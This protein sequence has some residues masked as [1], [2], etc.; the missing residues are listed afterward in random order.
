MM[1][2]GVDDE[3]ELDQ[4]V[5]QPEMQSQQGMRSPLPALTIHPSTNAETST[6][7]ANG[8]IGLSQESCRSPMVGSKVEVKGLTPS[9]IILLVGHNFSVQEVSMTEIERL[10]EKNL[11]TLPVRTIVIENGFCANDSYKQVEKVE[12]IIGRDHNHSII[13]VDVLDI[14]ET[15][16]LGLH[17]LFAKQLSSAE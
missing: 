7:N 10:A 1:I 17:E 12:K 9:Q 5:S 3:M 11:K 13:T 6:S 8:E 15:E 16:L 4:P 14:S 2:P